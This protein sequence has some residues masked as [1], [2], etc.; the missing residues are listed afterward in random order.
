M[1]NIY[2]NSILILDISYD[3]V[4]KFCI[5]ELS[6][7]ISEIFYILIFTFLIFP[8]LSS[9][10]LKNILLFVVAILIIGGIFSLIN[11]PQGRTNEVTLD[12]IVARIKNN[13][14]E[15]ITISETKIEAVLKNKNKEFTYKEPTETIGGL[16]KNFN[17]TPETIAQLKIKIENPS[18]GG[19]LMNVLLPS[20]LPFLL[21]IGLLYFMSK[22]LKGAGMQAFKFTE[23]KARK[24]NPTDPR[25]RVTFT[26][27]AGMKEVKE[28]LREVVD[29]LKNPK[30]FVELGAK[31]PKGVLLVGPPGCGKTLL[32]RA[33]AGE[34]KVPF[35]H[36][37]G[38]EFVELFV[39]VGAGRVRSLFDQAKKHLPAIIFVDELDAVG[40][41]RGA[42]LG[43]GHDEREQTL[44]QILVEMDGF[45]PN[46]GL[47]VMSATNRPDILD[48]ALLRPGR[49]DRHITVPLP[50]IK[51][52]E[53]ILKIHAKNKPFTK[54]VSLAK[55]AQRTP[56]F[57][58]ADLAN[59]L[60]EAAIESA[61]AR[62]KN[63]EELTILNS[64][65][66]VMLGHERKSRVISEKEK[67]IIAYHESGHA[68]VAHFLPNSDPVH[69][70]SIISRGQAGGYTIKL[71]TEDKYLRSKAEFLDNIASALGGYVAEKET[72]NDMT[73]GASSDL[74]HA[75]KL[76]RDCVMEYGMSD[77]L[78]PRTFGEKQEMIFL[79]K[80]I[81][82][83]RDYSEKTAEL[84]DKEIN[85]IID[86]CY[87]KAVEI[88]REKKE[89]LEKLVAA[90]LEKETIEREDF[91]RVVGENN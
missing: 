73:T 81:T 13:E 88:V 50:D 90:L 67:K 26:D 14:I 57:S 91:L 58:G 32:A 77:A 72:F 62:K 64:I 37:S 52:R 47:V 76:A 4:S 33:V 85:K 21:L 79:G 61:S 40:R 16:L 84:I 41:H 75:T 55:I 51:E 29:F 69:K 27:V 43:G 71:P 8:V 2:G 35:Y 54:D 6:F 80:E 83:S 65:E 66:K 39:G 59:L 48:P 89:T 18:K 45:E 11:I 36:M 74:K 63:I 78:G 24:Y 25:M 34:A 5:F 3:S 7:F 86:F 15:T 49:F 70:V 1:S 9:N 23:S 19:F 82:E 42:G 53:E 30:Q 17:V 22:Q 68:I 44:N 60:N 28:Q 56:G 31:I 46:S 20:I 12:Q 10:L 87:K 38:S